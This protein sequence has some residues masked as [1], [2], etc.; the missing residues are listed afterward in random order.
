MWFISTYYFGK[1]D[2]PMSD[3]KVKVVISGITMVVTILKLVIQHRGQIKRGK[4]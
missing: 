3:K 1:G 2:K 4:L